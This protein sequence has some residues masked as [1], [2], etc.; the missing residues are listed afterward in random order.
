M[1]TENEFP[2]I[3][4]L[5]YDGR[6]KTSAAVRTDFQKLV[7]LCTLISK[8]GVFVHTDFQKLVY[9]ENKLVHEFMEFLYC[10][11]TLSFSTFIVL[12]LS[13]SSVI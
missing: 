3:T 5:M 9:I 11:L 2:Q 6:K 4:N 13:C 8:T 12:S 7:H 10:A 1:S